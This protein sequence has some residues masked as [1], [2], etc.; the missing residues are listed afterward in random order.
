MSIGSVG[1][2]AAALTFAQAAPSPPPSGKISVPPLGIRGAA[3]LLKTA[4]TQL[5]AGDFNGA[6]KTAERAGNESALLKDYASFFAAQAALRLQDFAQVTAS[7]RDVFQFEPSSPM[8]GPTAS[9][10]ING[11]IQNGKTADALQLLTDFQKQIPQPQRLILSAQVY[12]ASSD[13]VKAAHAYE[14]VYYHYP[15]SKEATDAA[16]ALVDLKARLGSAYPPPQAVDMIFRAQKLFD[17]KN[18][19]GA[20]IELASAALQLTGADRDLARVRLGVADYLLN[21]TR[22]AFEYLAGLKVEDPE[23]DA[24]RIA[25]LVRCAR[26]LDR[27]ADVKPYLDQLKQTHPQS[28][29]RMDTLISVADQAR[30][31]NDATASALLYGE[32]AG[33][34]PKEQRAGWCAWQVA[35]QSYRR[36]AD[37]T[38]SRLRLYLQ[39]YGDSPDAN[40]ALYFLGRF[41]ERKNEL[42]VAK[43][44]YLELLSK[45]PNT[46]YALQA[47]ER[48]KD[49]GMSG[50]SPDSELQELFQGV[51]WSVRPEFPS[52]TPGETAAIRMQRAQAL[53][54]ANMRD[55]AEGEL[56]YGAAADGEQQNLYA[57]EL[58][59]L[60]ASS[61]ASD[62]AMRVIKH[63]A[64]GYIYMPLDQAPLAFWKLA[65]PM[66]YRLSIERYSHN[67]SLDPFL[68]AALIRQESEFNPRVISHANA[69]G[70]M[71]LLPGTGRELA[72]RFGV[73]RLPPVQL[74][75]P[76]RNLQLGTL[77]FHNLLDSY[78]GQTELALAS[79]NAGPGRANLWRTWGP[80]RE[81]AEFVEA[82]PFHETR[83]Y[84][85]VVLRNA[86][87][88]R[89]LYSGTKPDVPVYRP[90]PAPAKRRSSSSRRRTSPPMKKAV[91]HP[92]V[93]TS[94]P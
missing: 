7:A 72:R 34:F 87:L 22:E 93:T 67:Q 32:C 29:W 74:L 43:A 59:K 56:R 18:A 78:G 17:A 79:Y 5:S 4:Q 14:Q 20:K 73:R 63:Y 44:S 39:H 68:V 8:L 60:S 10:A 65:F 15:N 62:E 83:N 58:A 69:Y 85:Q 61:N 76:E 2:A 80:F 35:F 75:L 31:D 36:D 71:Q 92:S 91:R 45:F 89:R 52:F 37:D 77:Y 54:A 1:F 38:S 9:L 70:L 23:A 40:D 6:L 82:I 11:A 88:Y 24:E 64:P 84:V 21:N 42:P 86:D 33:D 19:A 53:D 25:Y 57:F 94:S 26:K 27:K 51:H 13:G 90:K 12:D 28:L 49:P 66:A 48:L 55:L 16:N 30:V 47:R 81:Q 46:Y 50:A 41:A 3:A